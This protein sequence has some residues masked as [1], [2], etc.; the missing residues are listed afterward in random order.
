MTD[1]LALKCSVK[2]SH[3]FRIPTCRH[4]ISRHFWQYLRVL[5]VI[6][7][8]FSK[9]HLNSYKMVHPGLSLRMLTG[10]GSPFWKERY[11]WRRLCTIRMFVLQS[12]SLS[13]ETEWHVPSG[14]WCKLLPN[15]L[16]YAFVAANFAQ[17]L[18]FGYTSWPT[19]IARTGAGLGRN[20]GTVLR[21]H[22]V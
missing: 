8:L 16:T 6:S 12:W 1:K 21:G 9:G 11:A 22:D 14:Q 5:T 20:G 2:E 15:C 10:G 3:T 18:H 7:Q 13:G 4:L 19:F 17:V